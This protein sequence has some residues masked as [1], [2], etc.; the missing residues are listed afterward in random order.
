VRLELELDTAADCLMAVGV[1]GTV[2]H[3]SALQSLELQVYLDQDELPYNHTIDSCVVPLLHALSA[4][5]Q[6][7]ALKL[8]LPALGPCSAPWVDHLVQLTSLTISTVGPDPAAADVGLDLSSWSRLTNLREL[9]LYD[10]TTVQPASSAAGPFAFPSNLTALVLDSSGQPHAAKMASWLTHLPG[11]LQLQQLDI[12]YPMVE[13]LQL[14][15][16]AHPAAVLDLLMQHNPRLRKLRLAFH[17]SDGCHWAHTSWGAAAAGRPVA[18][19]PAAGDWRPGAAL[20]ALTG[21]EHLSGGCQ[22]NIK[23]P[24]DWQHLAQLTALTNLDGICFHYSPLLQA[25][26]SLAV[27]QLQDCCVY[28]SGRDLGYVLLACPHL[29]TAEVCITWP[30]A[31]AAAGPCDAQLQPHPTL[32]AVTIGGCDSWAVQAV[33]GAGADA[34]QSGAGSAAAVAT[35]FGALAPVLRGVSKLGLHGWPAGSSGNISSHVGATCPDLSSCTALTELAFGCRKDMQHPVP[36]EQE[37]LLTM[38][39]PLAQ[40]QRLELCDVPQVNARVVLILQHMLPQL[41]FVQLVRCGS[42]LPLQPADAGPER[43]Q[44]AVERVKQL[45][46]P[47]L[48]LKL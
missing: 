44:Q 32:K 21:L 22:L 43:Q 41:Q 26:A 42:Q 18:G 4:L 37:D 1:L 19:G 25:V 5:R 10:V 20:S 3:W 8:L 13:H 29:H 33:T 40:L 11:C 16:A 27:L 28:L 46:R 45:L 9:R 17:E 47:G 48:V 2:Q 6:L 38:V 15:A 24:G 39:G 23:A 35:H 14:H 12:R 36:L 30:L 7:R 34:A 31:Q